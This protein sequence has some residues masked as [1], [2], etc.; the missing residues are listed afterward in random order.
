MQNIESILD[1][2]KQKVEA[3]LAKVRRS[4]RLETIDGSEHT[5]W[6]PTS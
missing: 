5:A 6:C 4:A 2:A 3:D 1:E